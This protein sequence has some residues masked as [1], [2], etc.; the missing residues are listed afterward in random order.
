MEKSFREIDQAEGRMICIRC[1][2]ENPGDRRFCSC[3]NCRLPQVIEEVIVKPATALLTFLRSVRSGILTGVIAGENIELSFSKVTGHLEGIREKFLAQSQ[4]Q[5]APGAEDQQ[6][7]T[8][9]AIDEFLEGV[10][11]MKRFLEDGDPSHLERGME[12]AEGA[13]IKFQ[14]ALSD[15]EN[16]IVHVYKKIDFYVDP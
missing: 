9:E 12:I 3:C 5:A 10:Y 16:K 1:G 4:V 8:L 11:E 7:G 2:T 15:V 6:K 13:D 14:A